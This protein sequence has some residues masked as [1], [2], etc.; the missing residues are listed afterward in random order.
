MCQPPLSLASQR[1]TSRTLKVPQNKTKLTASV[2]VS[3]YRKFVE[4]ED[5]EAL[6]RFIVERFDER[7]FRPVRDS[8][9]KH[10]FTTM[11]IACLVIETLE[12]F[13]QGL[14]DTKNRSKE[15]FREFFKRN[16]ALSEFWQGDDWFFTD[17]RCG[18]LHQGETRGGWKILRRGALIDVQNRTINATTFLGHLTDS[19]NYYSVQLKSDEVLLE[20]FFR[21]MDAICANCQ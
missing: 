13:Y 11:A 4:T 2:S 6:G 19:V 17:I 21:K 15:M 18:I 16:P 8:S 14:P 7:Y 12:S 3:D 10:G 5:R 20:K 9:S 1:H